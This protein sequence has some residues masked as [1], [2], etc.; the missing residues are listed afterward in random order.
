MALVI[1]SLSLISLEDAESENIFTLTA[2]G[3]QT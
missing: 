2:K 3:L 1:D